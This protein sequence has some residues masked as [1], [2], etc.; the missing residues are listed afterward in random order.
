MRLLKVWM[1]LSGC[2]AQLAPECLPKATLTL[3]GLC[4]LGR[5]WMGAAPRKALQCSQ[6]SARVSPNDY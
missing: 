2:A 1:D 4:L 3:A 5:L 6:P